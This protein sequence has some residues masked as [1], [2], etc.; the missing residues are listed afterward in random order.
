MIVFF[1]TSALVKAYVDEPGS[2]LVLRLWDDASPPIGSV[3][4]YAET[5]A[6]LARRLREGA[7]PELIHAVAET[8]EKHWTNILPMPVDVGV[9]LTCRRLVQRYPL[10]GADA[11][12]L[13]SAIEARTLAGEPVTFACAD[14]RLIEAAHAEGFDV[15]V[16]R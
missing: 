2:D 7:P 12:H 10:R 11:V 16:T 1:D 6:A 5:H 13:A 4:V 9:L 8:F 14:D 15:R 3:L